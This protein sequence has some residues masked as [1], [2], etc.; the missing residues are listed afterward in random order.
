LNLT[1]GGVPENKLLKG[2]AP[3]EKSVKAAKIVEAAASAESAN[4]DNMSQVQ[5]SHT[6]FTLAEVLITLGI[7]GIVAAMTLPS[8]IGNAQK[9]ATASHVHKFYNTMNNALLRAI[10]DYG[11]VKEWMPERKMTSYNDEVKF[12]KSYI[13]PYIKY[14][15]YESCVTE[16]SD[17]DNNTRVCVYLPQGL[18]TFYID[19]NGADITYY[20]NGKPEKSTRNYFAFQLNKISSAGVINSKTT[21]EPYTHQWNGEY[22]GLTSASSTWTCN[23]NNEQNTR[24]GL[25]Y[26]TKLLQMNNW[27]ITDDY[28]W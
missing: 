26:C 23:K 2:F 12:L 14:N 3:V 11:D 25:S 24:G 18:M 27:E 15:R 6:A 22:D 10:A 28:P 9:K 21:I 13:F 16:D 20:V 17:A 4:L 5:S 19:A 1:G 8:V 7:I